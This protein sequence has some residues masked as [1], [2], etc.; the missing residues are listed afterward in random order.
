MCPGVDTAQRTC[1]GAAVNRVKRPGRRLPSTAVV[2]GEA[3]SQLPRL[4]LPLVFQASEEEPTDTVNIIQAQPR[5]PRA[6]SPNPRGL[7]AASPSLTL[8]GKVVITLATA[9]TLQRVDPD[10]S[11]VSRLFPARATAAPCRTPS[12]V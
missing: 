2:P 10:S 5:G 8:V 3:V 4:G 12:T 6:A 7:S 1:Q 9:A 11:A